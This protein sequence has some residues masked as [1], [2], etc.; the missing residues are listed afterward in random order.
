MYINSAANIVSQ[1]T[2][3]LHVRKIYDLKPLVRRK[4]LRPRIAMISLHIIRLYAFIVFYVY[5]IYACRSR[6]SSTD[7]LGNYAARETNTT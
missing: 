5:I 7:F 3:V 2:R 1:C 6:Y 4:H